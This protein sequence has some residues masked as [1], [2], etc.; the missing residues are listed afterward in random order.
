MK[1]NWERALFI[2]KFIQH[3]RI[4][5]LMPIENLKYFK[6]DY[7]K[8]VE[9]PNENSPWQPMTSTTVLLGNDDHY[10]VSAEVEIP[11]VLLGKNLF[12][13]LSA[14]LKRKLH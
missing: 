3:Y 12:L 10:W 5:N 7:K 2:L 9:R 14:L 8:G 6:C 13:K 11:Q 4:S 1:A